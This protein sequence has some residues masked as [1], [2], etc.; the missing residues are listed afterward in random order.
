MSP[1]LRKMFGGPRDDEVEVPVVADVTPRRR[2]TGEVC[3]PGGDNSERAVP[4]VP[5]EVGGV[6]AVGLL[7]G[8][9]QVEIAVVFIVGP[10]RRSL[11]FRHQTHVL[12]GKGLLGQCRQRP[13]PPKSDGQECRSDTFDAHSRQLVSRPSAEW[14]ITR[15]GVDRLRKGPSTAASRNPRAA[16]AGKS[17]NLWFNGRPIPAASTGGG[18]GQSS[19]RAGRFRRQVARD[20]A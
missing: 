9:Q 13:D 11:V 19:W 10:R 1:L 15:A 6:L 12:A 4:V 7:P 8:D 18:A 16:A 2:G 14:F 17:E 5:V 3:H 20:G